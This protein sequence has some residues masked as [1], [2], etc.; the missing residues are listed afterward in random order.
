MERVAS[1]RCIRDLCNSGVRMPKMTALSA[2]VVY[3]R[4]TELA[5]EF[6]SKV[7]AHRLGHSTTIADKYFRQTTDQHFAR[8]LGSASSAAA[9]NENAAPA[10]HPLAVRPVSSRTGRSTLRKARG[11]ATGTTWCNSEWAT[12]DPQL[13]PNHWGESLI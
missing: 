1:T 4:A 13:L 2:S 12:M 8:A 5:D 11:I 10:L 6:P 7:V 3:A 9:N